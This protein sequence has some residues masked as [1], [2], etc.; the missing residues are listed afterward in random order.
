M[1]FFEVID[2]RYSYRGEFTNDKL[3]KLEIDK[4]LNAALAAPR[5]MNVQ[6]TSYVAVEDE[7]L[8]NQIGKLIN[9]NGTRTA[10]FI[11]VMLSEDKSDKTNF[12]FEVEN[13]SA[14]CENIL[15]AITALGYA[16]VWTDG[17]L[18]N[19]EINDGVRKILNIPRDKK[20]KAVLPIGKPVT[21]GK[22]KEKSKIEEAVVFNR[23]N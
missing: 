23:F 1:E 21:D 14:A 3:S 18:R 2:K 5:A 9:R 15:L 13:Y 8:I 20:I 4:I 10:P 16:T 11:L 7:K 19:K 22:P 12:N 17:I 6:S